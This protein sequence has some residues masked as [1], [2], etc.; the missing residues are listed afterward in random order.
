MNTQQRIEK[1]EAELAELKA[2][3]KQEKKPR[4]EVGDVYF[5]IS[6]D[7]WVIPVEWAENTVDKHRLAIGNAYKTIAEAERA[8]DRLLLIQELRK[9][10][11]WYEPTF[12]GD[13]EYTFYYVARLKAWLVTSCYSYFE[14]PPWGFFKDEATT[15]AAIEKFKDRLH[16]FLPETLR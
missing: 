2:N 4:F 12:A 6:L 16:L 10:S 7:G 14:C 1:I 13:C 15:I 9:F 8:R 5:G 3:I 11:E